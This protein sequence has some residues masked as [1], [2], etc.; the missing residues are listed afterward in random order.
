MEVPLETLSVL[1]KFS[2]QSL[3]N[4]PNIRHANLFNRIRNT[5]HFEFEIKGEKYLFSPLYTPLRNEPFMQLQHFVEQSESFLDNLKEFI[6]NTLFV[7]S[8]VIEEN[9][10][11]LTHEQD[12]II[13]RLLHRQDSKFEVKFYSHFQ[14]ELLNSYTDKIYLGRIFIDLQ[15]F[16]REHFGLNEYFVSILEQNN[17]IQERARHKLRFYEEYIKTELKEIDYLS[18]EVSN[19][20][21]ERIKLFPN[22]HPKEIPTIELLEIMD[23]LLSI[24]NLMIELRENAQEFENKLRQREENTFAKYLTKFSKDLINDIKYLTKLFFHLSQKI[25]KFSLV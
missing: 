10:Y 23:N 13:S 11:Y 17:K 2:N 24:Q 1:K 19:E 25:S 4:F 16:E 15:K 5:F 3:D 6:I 22:C 12:I 21:M 20:A 14:D 9:S 18:K 8:S 7:Y